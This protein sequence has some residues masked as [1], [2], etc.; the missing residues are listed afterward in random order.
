MYLELMSMTIT[1]L[2]ENKSQEHRKTNQDISKHHLHDFIGCGS[3]F[4][5]HPFSVFLLVARHKMGAIQD[6][7][8]KFIRMI[9][10][11]MM[12][13]RLEPVQVY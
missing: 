12:P 2:E 9:K 4:M 8:D 5:R 3:L 11:E 10:T 1:P 7:F 6:V 13:N